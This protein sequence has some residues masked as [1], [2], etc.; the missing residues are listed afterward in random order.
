VLTVNDQPLARWCQRVLL[1]FSPQKVVVSE[2]ANGL[3]AVQ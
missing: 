3:E 1:M 2:A